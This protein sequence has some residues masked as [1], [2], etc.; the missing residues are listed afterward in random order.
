MKRLLLRSH[1]VSI[2]TIVTLVGLAT[3]GLSATSASAAPNDPISFSSY[4]ISP[5]P[6]LDPLVPPDHLV[7]LR[8]TYKNTT[9]AFI[10]ELTL[11]LATFGP[12]TTRTQLGELLIEPNN[13]DNL[14]VTA[15]KTS[16]RL[17]NLAPGVTKTW[18]VT[19]R[20]EQVLGSGA[21][22]VFAIGLVPQSSD[23][24]PSAAIAIPW[25]FNSAV[26]PTK[27]VLAVPI[28]TL[29]TNLANGTSTNT[30]S[31]L[32][33]AE[34]LSAILRSPGNSSVSW[35]VDSAISTWANNLVT[36]TKT[37][38][39]EELVAALATLPAGVPVVPYGH[40]DISALVRAGKQA[41]FGE[42]I[43]RTSQSSAGNPIFYT[44]A[45]GESDRTTVS[46]L[47]TQ[48]VRSII[49]NK[50]IHDNERVTTP[51]S[52]T[53][54]SNKVLVF[55]VASSNC[56]KDMESNEDSFFRATSCLKAEIGMITAESPQIAR[57]IIVLAPNG[58]EIS[59]QGLTDL[60]LQLSN[61]NWMQLASLQEI[62]GQE[63]TQSF[64]A[65]NSGKDRDFSRGLL[66]LSDEIKVNT[67]SVSALYVDPELAASFTAARLLG[68]SDLWASNTQ[69]VKYFEQNSKL[70]NEYLDAIQ[71]EASA[72][73]TTPQASSQIPITIVNTSDRDVSVSLALTSASASRFSAQPSGLIQ[74]AQGQRVTVPVSISLI[75]A[76]IVTV[77]AQLIAPNG[78][79]F[80]VG[81]EIQI[82]SAAYSQFART[83]V[84]GAFG[85]LLALAL[86]NFIQRLRERRRIKSDQVSTE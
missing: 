74:V 60:S 49:S 52:V 72:Q 40:A 67:E 34:R 39:A 46:L 4:L 31:D 21:A 25:F 10:S 63:A 69:A 1:R 78:E 47:N 30:A 53:S 41:E 6:N 23:Y 9:D 66:R 12:I 27:V 48:N 2:A 55:D 76:G 24:G 8:G 38:A 75:G 71:L 37:A 64:I 32:R 17:R 20:G 59:S 56:L 18:Q 35:L 62:A 19:F 22:G 50:S 15:T 14:A 28:T 77:Q 58:W 11:D 7:T 51:A 29:N 45:S 16:A 54:S 42:V 3:L 79:R 68:Y 81:K 13:F 70:L 73:I 65:L 33:E 26:Q 43:A 57:S 85:L 86:S 82:S 83:L 44:P 5:M 61:H 36:N 80:G 84:V